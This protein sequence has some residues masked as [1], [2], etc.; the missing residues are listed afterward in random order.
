MAV[1]RPLCAQDDFNEVGDVYVQ[2]WK[3]C[4]HGLLPQAFLAKLTH[5]RW[6][7]M[8]RADPSA[9]LDAFEDARTVGPAVVTY[10]R[11]PGREGFPYLVSPY[12]PP[13]VVGTA[14]CRR[15]IVSTLPPLP[16]A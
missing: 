6:R 15:L 7:G 8:L 16:D 14:H 13:A 1:I 4:Y 2:R 5:D 3:A 10:A 9:S 11:E 12:L